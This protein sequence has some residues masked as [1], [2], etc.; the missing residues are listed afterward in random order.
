[1]EARARTREKNETEIAKPQNLKSF[2][3]GMLAE[4]LKNTSDILCIRVRNL[5]L[6]VDLQT[7]FFCISQN[8]KNQ[9]KPQICH[10][11][12]LLVESFAIMKNQK[13]FAAVA[14]NFKTHP[15]DCN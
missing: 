3:E 4:T 1:L 2:L 10:K 14:C 5:K 9:K 6:S 12:F 7:R 11:T 13:H 8:N 15:D